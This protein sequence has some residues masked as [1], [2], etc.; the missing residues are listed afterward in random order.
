MEESEFELQIAVNKHIDSCF[1]GSHN[2]D[3]KY[4]HIANENRDADQAYWNKVLGVLPG[5]LD[6]MAGWPVSQ[7]GVLEL[8]VGKN[9][10]TTP[11]N[12]FISWARHIGWHTGVA[13]TVKQAHG[14]LCQWGLKPAHNS[15]IE[16][17]YRT[18][19]EKNKDAQNFYMP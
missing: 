19:D 16:P 12:K 17:D 14:V 13:Y 8:K 18:W 2:P 9:K 4:W 3:F 6:L 15:I 5:V 10:L 1:V 11:Q 7:C